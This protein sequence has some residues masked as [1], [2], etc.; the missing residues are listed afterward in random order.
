VYAPAEGHGRVGEWLSSWFSLVVEECQSKGWVVAAGGDFNTALSLMDHGKPLNFH[1]CLELVTLLTEEGGFVDS[2]CC[3]HTGTVK[4]SWHKL[5]KAPKAQAHTPIESMD[6]DSTVHLLGFLNWS[7]GVNLLNLSRQLQSLFNQTSITQ[8]RINL[9]LTAPNIPILNAD[10]LNHVATGADHS[11]VMVSIQVGDAPGV[12]APLPSAT[13]KYASHCLEQPATAAK[14]ALALL[15]NPG[16]NK[17]TKSVFDRVVSA[18]T[19][20]LLPSKHHREGEEVGLACWFLCKAVK[21]VHYIKMLVLGSMPIQVMDSMCKLASAPD[22]AH[23]MLPP[24]WNDM[25]TLT[26]LSVVEHKSKSLW[27]HL[28]ML[29]WERDQDRVGQLLAY[30]PLNTP[31]ALSMFWHHLTHHNVPKQVETTTITEDSVKTTYCNPS[32]VV[33]AFSRFWAG[34]YSAMV[35]YVGLCPWFHK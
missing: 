18:A 19:T 12:N 11:P 21:M 20:T 4:F 3:T 27:S 6:R 1:L 28:E 2:F 10:I 16:C 13:K 22:W 25:E 34:L 15:P 29:L 23:C 7:N 33:A 32:S 26:Y 17:P 9:I 5:A 35:P 31:S 30:T 24:N 14:F 8:K